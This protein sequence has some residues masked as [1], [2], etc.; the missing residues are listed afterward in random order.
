MGAEK[1]VSFRSRIAERKT[2]KRF[3]A[4]TVIR[5]EGLIESEEV[6]DRIGNRGGTANVDIRPRGGFVVRFG[7]FC[8]TFPKP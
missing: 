3:P 6:T 5:A 7:D 1:E 8:F 4:C 2:S